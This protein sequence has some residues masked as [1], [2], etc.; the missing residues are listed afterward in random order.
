MNITIVSK[1]Y[2][3]AASFF[4]H[5]DDWQLPYSTILEKLINSHFRFYS[6]LYFYMKELGH[7]VQIIY[8]NIE[9]LQLKWN[10][11][12]N[13]NAS[14]G[15]MQ[16]L[17][18]QIKSFQTTIVLVN[19]DFEYYDPLH[20]I[21]SKKIP[22]IG[23]VSC[24]LPP[25]QIFKKLTAIITLNV[26]YV[27]YFKSIN[28]PVH[29]VTAGFD[30]RL[31]LLY[32]KQ[33]KE[34]EFS[35]IGGIGKEH[36]K[37]MEHLKY[38]IPKTPVQLWGYGYEGSTFFKK[39]AKKILYFNSFNKRYRGQAWGIDMF[40]ILGNSKITFNIHGDIVT[41][42]TVNMR[43]YEATGMGALLLTEYDTKLKEVFEPEVEVVTYKNKE[44]AI[45]KY[46]H[47]STYE[48]ERK[49][50]AAAGQKKTLETYNYHT[51]SKKII[52][53]FEE[54]CK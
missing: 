26:P 10:K 4:I 46:L 48:T 37:R 21:C 27:A 32:E 28:I 54:Y 45:E 12:Y 30:P 9:Q 47:Y 20:A 42:P 50:I 23:W 3:S 53:I 39:I 38:L 52:S 17:N 40:K 2:S 31:Q 11:E 29:L 22:L 18:A 1:Y 8:P 5:N 24:P 33:K 44:E 43:L 16:I 13:N 14:V 49:A 34:I 35:F 25:P 41:Q 15:N 36:N 19:S 51:I 6:S 7:E